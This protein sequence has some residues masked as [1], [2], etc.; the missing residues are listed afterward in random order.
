M[1]QAFSTEAV[2]GVFQTQ[3]IATG[4]RVTNKEHRNWPRGPAA[5]LSAPRFSVPKNRMGILSSQSKYETNQ[6]FRITELEKENL[7]FGLAYYFTVLFLCTHILKQ[8]VV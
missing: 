7:S 1:D 5:F 8:P 4:S 3:T 6:V 2:G